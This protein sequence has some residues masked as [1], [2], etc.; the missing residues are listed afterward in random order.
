MN[1]APCGDRESPEH[2]ALCVGAILN[3]VVVG[4]ETSDC[5]TFHVW[6]AIASIDAP[7]VHHLMVALMLLDGAYREGEVS[8]HRLYD[9]IPAF[10]AAFW[11][12]DARC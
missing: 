9:L 1:F 6:A 7:C 11:S 3:A 10:M 2:M 12:G 4:D 5:G 8:P